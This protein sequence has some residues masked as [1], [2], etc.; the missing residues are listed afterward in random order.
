MKYQ[1]SESQNAKLEKLM[2]NYID[3]IIPKKI[4]F[5]YYGV[6]DISMSNKLTRDTTH[7]TGFSDKDDEVILRVYLT[8]Y[9][10]NVA[11]WRDSL[12]MIELELEFERLLNALFGKLKWH[13]SFLKWVNDN[14]PELAKLD[15]KSVQ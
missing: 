6:S 5:V 11:L 7:I 14:L 10:N 13:N 2:Y 3:K 15:I 8:N 4:E 12:P 1:I 9:F